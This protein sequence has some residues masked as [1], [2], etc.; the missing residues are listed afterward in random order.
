MLTT[1]RPVDLT[2]AL[3]GITPSSVLLWLTLDG[4][5]CR[6]FRLLILAIAIRFLALI[7]IL[8]VVLIH[9]FTPFFPLEQ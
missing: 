4:I 8:I 3:V 1:H 7:W 9:H 2:L 5:W 6:L